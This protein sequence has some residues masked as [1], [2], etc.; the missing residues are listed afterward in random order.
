MIENKDKINLEELKHTFLELIS[1]YKFLEDC[2][3]KTTNFITDNYYD[4]LMIVNVFEL[5]FSAEKN[6]RMGRLLEWLAIFV[7]GR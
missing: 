7:R 5:I 3:Y 2:Y 6:I 4:I 1:N